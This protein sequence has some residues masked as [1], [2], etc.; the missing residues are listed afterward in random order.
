MKDFYALVDEI[1]DLPEADRQAAERRLRERFEVERAVLVL[2]MSEFSLS[3]RRSG[4][5]AH[6]CLIRRV[7]RLAVPIVAT[8][9]GEVLKCEADNVFA[10]FPEPRGAVHA[11]LAINRALAGASPPDAAGPPPAVGIG[12]DFGRV[13]LIPGRDAFG[14]AVNVAHKL[15]EDVA[16]GGEILVS[17]AT[18]ERLEEC[19][20]EPLSL[21][22]SG[23][24]L[25]AWRIAG[26]G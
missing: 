7:Q 2:D 9:G 6:L 19:P 21:S 14:D 23:L 8:H 18:R 10:V 25:K 20:A 3:V 22:V 11:A 26:S 16:R 17:D 13:L 15:G 24:H 4:I 1:A 5:V 12:I